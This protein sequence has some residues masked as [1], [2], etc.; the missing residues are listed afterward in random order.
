MVFGHDAIINFRPYADWVPRRFRLYLEMSPTSVRS[1]S[2]NSAHWRV[3][4]S[5]IM[6]FA[7]RL[8]RFLDGFIS[9]GFVLPVR[10]WI[11]ASSLRREVKLPGAGR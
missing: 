4:L 6:N 10:I 7:A 1:G 11:Y 5:D 3:L 2:V 9:G 8:F